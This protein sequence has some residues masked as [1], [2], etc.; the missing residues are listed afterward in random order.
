MAT[1]PKKIS[2]V[3]NWPTPTNVKDVRGFL[4]LAGYYR[5]FVKY[6]GIIA[7]N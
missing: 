3:Q 6:F 4:G 1:N 5:K 2:D 7:S